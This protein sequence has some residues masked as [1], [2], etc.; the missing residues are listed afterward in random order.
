MITYFLIALALGVCLLGVAWCDFHKG[1][2]RDSGLLTFFWTLHH[3]RGNGINS[4]Q[5]IA[6]VFDRRCISLRSSRTC[7]SNGGFYGMTMLSH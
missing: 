3:F 5:R 6:L 7:S 1:N 2:R 4:K